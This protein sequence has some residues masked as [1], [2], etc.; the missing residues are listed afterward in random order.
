MTLF[1]QMNTELVTD[2][3]LPAQTEALRSTKLLSLLHLS[4]LPKKFAAVCLSQRPASITT[5]VQKACELIKDLSKFGKGVW[6][7]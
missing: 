6:G 3:S 4:S 5:E 1:M 2:S 7:A